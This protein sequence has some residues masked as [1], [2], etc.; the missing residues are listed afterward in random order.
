MTSCLCDI[1]LGH[2]DTEGGEPGP[3]LFE[4][5]ESTSG[6]AAHVEKPEA[7]LVTTGKYLVERSQRLSSSRIG[8]SVK[9]HFDLDFVTLRRIMVH[10]AARLEMEILHIVARPFAACFLAQHLIVLAVFPSTVHARHY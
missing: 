9:K 6:T 2:V 4:K 1:S 10:P 5:I 8:R 3:S 7:A